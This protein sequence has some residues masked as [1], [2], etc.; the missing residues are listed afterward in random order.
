MGYVPWPLEGLTGRWRF[1]RSWFR[2]S[3]NTYKVEQITYVERYHPDGFRPFETVPK[4]IWRNASI[5]EVRII[6][7]TCSRKNYCPALKARLPLPPPPP[8]ENE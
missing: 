5:E 6:Q 2:S 3:S 4:V 1:K 7:E 8:A